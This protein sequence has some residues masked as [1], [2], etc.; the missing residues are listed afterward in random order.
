MWD[1]LG[2]TESPALEWKV[3]ED[4]PE[5]SSWKSEQPW[6]LGSP[7]LAI[8]SRVLGKLPRVLMSFP[9]A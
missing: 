6:P 5:P 8:S 7:Y 9:R 2:A 3:L 4:R 1:I